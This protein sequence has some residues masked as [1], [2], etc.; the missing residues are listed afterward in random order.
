LTENKKLA[1]KEGAMPLIVSLMQQQM[2]D[3]KT[4]EMGCLVLKNI[5][6]V[7]NGA[8]TIYLVSSQKH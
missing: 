7:H 5:T 4:Q 2:Q 1:A 6:S 3:R 8:C